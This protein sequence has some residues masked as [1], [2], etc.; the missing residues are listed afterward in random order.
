MAWNKLSSTSLQQKMAPWKR[1]LYTQS[2]RAPSALSLCL[3]FPPPSLP[4]SLPTRTRARV[5]TLELVHKD[6]IK[7]APTVKVR[8][9]LFQWPL[10]CQHP[11][12]VSNKLSY[13]V[14][15]TKEIN[16][17][18]FCRTF[19][20]KTFISEFCEPLNFKIVHFEA[21][22]SV[23]ACV[24]RAGTWKLPSGVLGWPRAHHRRSTPRGC[25]LSIPAPPPDLAGY[26][27]LFFTH[28]LPCASVCH[29]HPHA[30]STAPER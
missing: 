21:C 9:T 24:R 15:Q 13:F 1:G 14:G 30:R 12:K 26:I 27:G 10:T 22:L 20:L 7:T 19:A 8:T 23:S 16:S 17:A 6:A 4:R 18:S 25:I 3:S 11:P 5:H 2:Q 29:K 28:C